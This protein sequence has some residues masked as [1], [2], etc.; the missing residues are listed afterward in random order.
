MVVLQYLITG[1]QMLTTGEEAVRAAEGKDGDVAVKP[2]Q[3]RGLWHVLQP[4]CS[5]CCNKDMHQM[6]AG[7]GTL[8]VW[9]AW[10]LNDLVWKGPLEVSFPSSIQD[11]VN[12]KAVLPSLGF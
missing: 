1:A 11:R 8:L 5:R 3:V 6:A 2:I 9:E 7:M 4:C 12:I 10:L